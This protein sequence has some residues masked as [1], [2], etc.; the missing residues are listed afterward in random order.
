MTCLL[1]LSI[2]IIL[3][4]EIDVGCQ[5]PLELISKINQQRLIE[6]CGLTVRKILKIE[7][8]YECDYYFGYIQGIQSVLQGKSYVCSNLILFEKY[9]RRGI[10]F[11][12]Q[13]KCSMVLYYLR[14]EP[15]FNSWYIDHYTD[16]FFTGY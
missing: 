15:D 6:D 12:G 4:N 13:L 7:N 9:R 14:Q 16:I 5:L 1:D 3:K 10:M 8:D 2:K 11:C